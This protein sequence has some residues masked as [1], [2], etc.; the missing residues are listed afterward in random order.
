MGL[1]NLSNMFNVVNQ[2]SF[3]H[4]LLN[5]RSFFLF[6]LNY[7]LSLSETQTIKEKKKLISTN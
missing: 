4:G 5:E 6:A 7:L 1:L 2:N 3:L